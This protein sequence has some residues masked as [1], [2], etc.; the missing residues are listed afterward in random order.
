MTD[1]VRKFH[2]G[3]S[4]FREGEG[5]DYACLVRGGKFENYKATEKGH[6]TIAM[7]T[8]GTI[9]GELALIDG[10][11]RMASARCVEEGYLVLID[12]ARFLAKLKALTPRQHGLFDALLMF[13]REAPLWSA[14]PKGTQ[15]PPL[16]DRAQRIKT[17]LP[18]IE[19]AHALTT[20]D[21]FLDVLAKMLIH[22]AKR[23]LPPD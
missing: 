8:A 2:M 12:R 14:P 4:V 18:Q 10:G 7:A 6:E 13:V 16:T 5:A 22:Y 17:M 11:R 21:A 1:Q 9:F 3:A 20:G 15:P 19:H 23:R